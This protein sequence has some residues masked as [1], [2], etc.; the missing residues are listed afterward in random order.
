MVCSAL[1][2][3]IFEALDLLKK[4]VAE[5]NLPGNVIRLLHNTEFLQ[6][7]PLVIS[8][9]SCKVKMLYTSS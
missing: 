2:Y 3:N 9:A 6:S 4:Y 8:I 7:S 1:F 5:I